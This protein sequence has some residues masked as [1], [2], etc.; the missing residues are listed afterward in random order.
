MRIVTD[1]EADE[2]V[3]Y[4]LECPGDRAGRIEWHALIQAVVP[5]D[6]RWAAAA[7]LTRRFGNLMSPDEILVTPFVLIGTIEQMAEQLLRNRERYGFTYY[8]VHGPY[9]DTFAPVIERVRTMGD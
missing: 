6:D 1:V 3:R 4:A 5:T 9:A 7:A 8:T 2:R